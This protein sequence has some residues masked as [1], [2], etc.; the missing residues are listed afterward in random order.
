MEKLAEGKTK[1]VYPGSSSTEVILKFK[2]DITALNGEKHNLLTGKGR[3]NAEITAVLFRQLNQ[4][5]VPTHFV[6]M[7][8]PVTMRVRRL[9]MLPLEIV[10]RNLAAG[11]FLKRL[12]YFKRGEK[13]RI[14]IV[15]FF[16]K[17]DANHDPLLTEDEV[18]LME[19]ANED[20]I[21]QMKKITR[22]VNQVLAPFFA[23]RGLTLV[24][25][26]IEFGR[27]STGHLLVG[28]ELNAD[29]MRLWD[30]ETGAIFDKDVYREGA[31]LN[32]VSEVYQDVYQRIVTGVAA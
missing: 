27:D 17:D 10:L 32:K 15:Q 11:H 24:D 23:K 3:M 14:P 20:E 25:F 29:S 31:E 30:I 4:A 8:D 21:A 28:D 16:F 13:L 9:K 1:I 22:Q 2:D 18:V 6:E 26:K 19:H 12:P 7:V 5:G